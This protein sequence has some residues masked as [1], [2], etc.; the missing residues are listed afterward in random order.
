MEQKIIQI[1]D[2]KLRVVCEEIPELEITS[3]ETKKILKDLDKTL[4]TQK[5]GVAISAPQIGITKQIFVIGGMIFDKDFQSGKT[6]TQNTEIKNRYY[7][8]PK[9]IK[10]SKETVEM[11]EGCLSIRGVYGKVTRPKKIILEYYNEHGDYIKEGASGFL[12]RVIQHEYDHLHGILFID[13]AHEIWQD[14][15]YKEY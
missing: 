3:K 13:K 9:I 12:S 14:D 5:D 8:N 6:K 1:G 4:K 10:T 11:E 2:E 7:I 15:K